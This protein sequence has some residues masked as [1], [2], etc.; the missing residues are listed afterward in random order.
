MVKRRFGVSGLAMAAAIVFA[1]L[2]AV[3][4]DPVTPPRP[5]SRQSNFIYQRWMLDLEAGLAIPTG[6]LAALQNNGV[7]LGG[8]VGYKL[9]PALALRGDFDIDFLQEKSRDVGLTVLH[10]IGGFE[11]DLTPSTTRWNI[12]LNLGAGATHWSNRG[13][14]PPPDDPLDPVI[15][16]FSS[17]YFEVNPGIKATLGVGMSFQIF[18]S[19]QYHA[20]FLGDSTAGLEVSGQP[21]DFAGI[22]P[23]TFGGRLL[24]DTL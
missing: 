3:A 7:T 20:M 11:V 12:I 17:F 10:F 2:P 18:F 22:F 24:A 8:G 21:F 1:T 14:I 19:A 6:D 15:G 5:P 4:Q 23:L 16:D 9:T 13:T